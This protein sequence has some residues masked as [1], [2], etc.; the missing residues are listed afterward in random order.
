MRFLAVFGFVAL[1]TGAGAQSSAH[2]VTVTGC[3]E[4]QSNPDFP[5]K[6][7]VPEHG[8]QNANPVGTT[9]TIG[10]DARATTA[11]TYDASAEYDL[12]VEPYLGRIVQ[13][14]G[15]AVPYAMY[16]GAPVANADSSTVSIDSHT[17]DMSHWQMNISHLVA[18]G[19]PCGATH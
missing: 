12:D 16:D 18:T 9:G 5:L 7:V 8:S 19:G 15:V 3:L 4:S 10:A 17:S 14:T 1:A 2:V 6:I 13:A 11:I